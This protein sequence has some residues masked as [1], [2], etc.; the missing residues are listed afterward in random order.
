MD[1]IRSPGAP[2]PPPPSS[3]AP[4]AGADLAPGGVCRVLHAMDV[5]RSLDL[6]RAAERLSSARPTTFQHKTRVPAGEGMSPPLRLVWPTAGLALGAWT[7]TA[8]VEV[9]L[10][11]FGAICVTSTLPIGV[12]LDELAALSALLYGHTE[13][14][15]RSRAIARELLAALRDAVVAP[16]PPSRVEEYVVFQARPG[17]RGVAALLAEARPRLARVLRAEAGP[18]SPQEVDDALAHPISYGGAEVC[19]VDWLGSILLGEDLEDERLVLELATVELEELRFLDA[20]LDREVDDA[21][22]LLA[23]QRTLRGALT[24]RRRELARVGRMQVDNA[25]LYQGIDNAWKLFGD[26]YLARLYRTAAD[27]FHLNDWDAVIERKLEVLRNIYE[28]L[29]DLAAHRRSEV[30]EWII[31]LLIAVDVMLFVVERG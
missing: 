12:S 28:S 9:A 30:L 24:M 13:L 17:P 19:L 21:Y 31:I 14:G 8:E 6:A 4:A 11:D 15:A 1:E 27:R 20:R 2:A 18:L 26:D 7:T 23:R 10:F 5:S 3:P 25:I 29:V 16:L 22:A